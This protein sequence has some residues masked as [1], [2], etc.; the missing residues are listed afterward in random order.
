[1][2]QR[3]TDQT[4]QVKTLFQPLQENIDLL[5]VFYALQVIKSVLPGVRCMKTSSSESKDSHSDHIHVLLV[6]NSQRDARN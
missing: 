2:L 6:F 1:M 5:S 4:T 3:L